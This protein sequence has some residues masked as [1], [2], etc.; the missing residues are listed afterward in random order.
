MSITA[1]YQLFRAFQRS[2]DIGF[3]NLAYMPRFSFEGEALEAMGQAVRTAYQARFA[4]FSQNIAYPG[5]EQGVDQELIS[6][7]VSPLTGGRQAGDLLPGQVG[8]RCSGP[9]L[10]WSWE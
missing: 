1:I 8:G 6:A 2:S 4:T 7:P 10:L 3:M 9:E 5:L